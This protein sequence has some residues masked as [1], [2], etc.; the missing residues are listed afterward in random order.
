MAANN[1]YFKLLLLPLDHHL[2]HM[3]YR[4]PILR[5]M[6]VLLLFVLF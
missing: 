3:A 6:L 4:L 2:E 5:N 1:H